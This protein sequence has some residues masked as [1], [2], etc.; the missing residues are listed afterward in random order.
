MLRSELRAMGFSALAFLILTS[1]AASWSYSAEPRLGQVVYITMTKACS[2]TLERCQT[3]DVIVG[4]LFKGKEGLLKRIDYS[5]DKD[6]AQV[7]TRKY[8]VIQVPALLFLDSEGAL[9]GMAAG[10]LT[11]K[12]IAAKLSQFGG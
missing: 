2:C 3:A 11:E 1:A 9:L 10:E 12:D 4:N 5:Q 7:Y 8:R 6:A